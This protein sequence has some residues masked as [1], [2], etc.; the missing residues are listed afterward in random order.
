MNS[1]AMRAKR[2][3]KVREKHGEIFLEKTSRI[4]LSYRLKPRWVWVRV[5][6]T[7]GN[8]C[9]KVVRGVK[10]YREIMENGHLNA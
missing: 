5:G 1:Q 9:I 4:P 10:C 8:A 3:G 6:C 2:G 7:C